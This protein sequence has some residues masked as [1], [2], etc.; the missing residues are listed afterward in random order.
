MWGWVG[1]FSHQGA[2]DHSDSKTGKL[3]IWKGEIA[4][5]FMLRTLLLKVCP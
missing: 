4:S 5:P 1:H 3:S 2:G